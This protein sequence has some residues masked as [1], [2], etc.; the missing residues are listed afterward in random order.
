ML[1]ALMFRLIDAVKLF[2][3]IFTLT[4]GGPGTQT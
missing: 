1:V 2:D 4:R 3:I